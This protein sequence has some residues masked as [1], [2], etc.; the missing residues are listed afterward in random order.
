MVW[1]DLSEAAQ[2]AI[3]QRHDKG[4]LVE[5]L[6]S[7]YNLRPVSLDRKLRLLRP[8]LDKDYDYRVKNL[9]VKSPKRVLCY[10][11]THFGAEDTKAIQL[12]IE[13]AKRFKPE[14]I[15]HLGDVLDWNSLSR[16]VKDTKSAP[17]QEERYRWYFHAE[18][19]NEVAPDTDKY[20]LWGNH[21]ER[22]RTWLATQGSN[23][24]GLEELSVDGL[25]YLDEL[26]WNHTVDEIRINPSDDPL[27]PAAE[28]YFI[29]GESARKGAGSS[30]RA[31]SDV[32]SG[33]SVVMGH[34][35]RTAMISRRTDHGTVY[36]YEVGTLASLMPTYA[37]FPDWTQSILTGIIGESF[38][39]FD[40]HKIHNGRARF[41]GEILSV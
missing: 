21:E 33:A 27:Y 40:V 31:E 39:D 18:Q 35:H 30:V 2:K 19:L 36:S 10:T 29:H 17:L 1:T 38:F 5:A 16:F 32:Y 25:L 37:R 12:V 15:I 3:I 9:F 24:A 7:E 20:V 28:L 41:G 8:N 4:E 11:D 23:I 14:I 34:A 22:L 6:A 26:G 13:I